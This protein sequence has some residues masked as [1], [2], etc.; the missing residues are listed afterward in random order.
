LFRI[1]HLFYMSNHTPYGYL[2]SRALYTP[3]GYIAR[4][5]FLIEKFSCYTILL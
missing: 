4:A 5:D 3:V 2:S 1:M